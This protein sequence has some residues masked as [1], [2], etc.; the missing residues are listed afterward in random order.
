[1]SS[2]QL[3]N[4]KKIWFDVFNNTSIVVEMGFGEIVEL[5][6]HFTNVIGPKFSCYRL[7]L[8]Q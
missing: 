8:E 2:L 5:F 6:H 7:S 1:M 4:A 3:S